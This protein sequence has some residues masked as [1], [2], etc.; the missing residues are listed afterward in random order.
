MVLSLRFC[1]LV[2]AVAVCL[3]ALRANALA[4]EAMAQKILDT[5]GFRGGMIVHLGC[6]DGQLTGEFARQGNWLV[7]GLDTDPAKVASARSY[8][9]EV[10][11]YGRVAV[12]TFD[13][14]HLPY[15]D[16]LVNL[17]VTERL[18][19]VSR[20]EAMR[21]LAPLGVLCEKQGDEWATTV[22]PRPENIDEWT[23]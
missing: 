16:N 15:A 7:H 19:N 21:V 20:N 3:I 13:G 6:G 17:I 11:L 8:L 12:D 4:D 23:H 14:R 22:K 5:T 9:Q 18:G 2:C 10:G 1:R